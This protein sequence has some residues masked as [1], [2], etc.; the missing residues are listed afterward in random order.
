[1]TSSISNRFAS[2]EESILEDVSILNSKLPA[3]K[4]Q[5]YISILEDGLD[6]LAVLGDI[7][8]DVHGKN[9]DKP[10]F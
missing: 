9:S 6:Q 2:V 5:S 1:M 7:A 8:P 3:S 10:V 4:C